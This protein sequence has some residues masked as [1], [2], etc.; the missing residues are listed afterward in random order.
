MKDNIKLVRELAEVYGE[1]FTGKGKRKQKELDTAALIYSN[2]CQAIALY[3]LSETIKDQGA[4]SRRKPF[5]M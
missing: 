3:E 2:L 4:K 1:N 5:G